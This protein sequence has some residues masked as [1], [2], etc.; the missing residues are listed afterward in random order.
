MAL[1]KAGST[2]SSHEEA[3][4]P[5]GQHGE[6]RG[7]Y[8]K[9]AYGKAGSEAGHKPE[10]SEGSYIEGDYGPAGVEEA[11]ENTG[12]G[13]FVEADYGTAGDVP[14]HA[15]DDPEGRYVQSAAKDVKRE[16]ESNDEA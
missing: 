6:S 3:Q 12:V 10:D 14:G 11:S 9:G 2:M 7:R 16:D 1:W 5:A 4:G 15:A 8:V 13:R